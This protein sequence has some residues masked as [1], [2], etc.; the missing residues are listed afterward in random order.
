[1][2][3]HFKTTLA[4]ITFLAFPAG[5][6]HATTIGF[7]GAAGSTRIFRPIYGSNIVANGVGMDRCRWNRSDAEHSPGLGNSTGWDWEFHS[8]SPLLASYRS[9]PYRGRVGRRKSSPPT[10]R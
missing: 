7:V 3:I 4:A 9:S 1:M 10:M 5:T 2:S 6:V 8:A